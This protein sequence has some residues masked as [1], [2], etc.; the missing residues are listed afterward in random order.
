[1]V[2]KN[3]RL[4]LAAAMPQV[5]YTCQTFQV[6]ARTLARVERLHGFSAPEKLA[7]LGEQ[8]KEGSTRQSSCHELSCV[9]QRSRL[10]R[11]GQ[12]GHRS[13]KQTD[14]DWTGVLLPLATL[15]KR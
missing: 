15:T 8:L 13:I 2:M 3:Q 1:M 6:A 14:S 9:A 7:W 10:P 5:K 12:D 11:N 4:Q